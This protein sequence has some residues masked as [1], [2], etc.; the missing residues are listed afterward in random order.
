MKICSAYK[1]YK[2]R[3]KMKK[4]NKELERGKITINEA[5]SYFGLSPI[6]EGNNYF[7][8]QDL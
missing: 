3:K 7:V 5:R 8:R 1:T 6:T 4:I 2:L